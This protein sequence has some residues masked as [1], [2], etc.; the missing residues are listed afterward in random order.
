LTVVI[1]VV[2]GRSIGEIEIIHIGIF[3]LSRLNLLAFVVVIDEG[4][5]GI[6]S[7]WFIRVYIGLFLTLIR[8]WL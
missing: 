7:I 3:I 8:I 4:I 2:V 6:V 5:M 1:A